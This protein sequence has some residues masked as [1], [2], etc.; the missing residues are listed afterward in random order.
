M[1]RS[2]VKTGK[3]WEILRHKLDSLVAV[4]YCTLMS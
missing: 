4:K 2:S 3:A 1:V